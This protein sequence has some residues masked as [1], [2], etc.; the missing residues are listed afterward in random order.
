MKDRRESFPAWKLLLVGMSVLLLLGCAGLVLLWVQH[1]E[2]AEKLVRL[3]SQMQE[4]AQ[5][6]RRQAELLPDELGET[7][8]LRKLRRSRRN[9]EGEQDKMMLVTYSVVPIKAYLDLCNSSRGFCLMGPP[10]PPGVPGPPGPTGAPGP[11]GRRGRPGPPG[12]ACPACCPTEAKSRSHRNKSKDRVTSHLGDETRD[13]LN[14]TGPV[15][16]QDTK[17]ESVSFQKEVI[18]SLNDTRTEN[19][20]Q[21]P[22][23]PVFLAVDSGGNI[24]PSTGGSDV[25]D[26]TATSELVSPRPDYLPAHRMNTSS[27]IRRETLKHL[28]TVSPTPNVDHD[29]KEALNTTDFEKLHHRNF[30]PEI[31]KPHPAENILNGSKFKEQLGTK[32]EPESELISKNDWDSTNVTEDVKFIS[33]EVGEDQNKN[34]FNASRVQTSS[35]SGPPGPPCP[36]CYPTEAKSRNYRNKAKDRV[37]SHLGDETRDVLNVTGPVKLQDTKHESVSFQKEVIVSLNDTRTENVTQT[38]IT[39]VFLA[40]DSG[41]NID[42][43]TGG[44]DVTD[45]TAT[46]ELVSPRPDYL[47]AHRMNTSSEIRRETLKHLTTVSPTPNVDHD[48]KEALN[49]TDFE[50]LHHRNFKP[51][52]PKPH[53]AENILNGSKFKEQ[54]GTKR[55][56][57]SELISKNDWDSKNVTEDVKFISDEVG[58]DQNKNTFN[59][60]R[61]QTSS[62]SDRVTSHLGDET[63]D[64]LN[65]TGPVKLQNTKHESVSFQKEVIVSLNDTRTENVT[66]TPITSVQPTRDSANVTTDAFIVSGSYERPDEKIQPEPEPSDEGEMVTVENS[67][68]PIK[69]LHGPVDTFN[70]SR[71]QVI[72]DTSFKS[73]SSET[74]RSSKTFTSDPVTNETRVKNA[75]PSADDSQRRNSLNGSRNIVDKPMKS[76][77]SQRVPTYKKSNGTDNEKM[78]KKGCNINAIKCSD[79]SINMQL[80]FGAWMS[81][82]SRPDDR[83]WVAEHF[84][85]RE[86]KQ[87]KNISDTKQKFIDI[88]KYYQGCGHVVYKNS[89]YFHNG[90]TN[91]LLKFTLNTKNT[92]SLEMPNSKYKGLRYLFHNSKTYFKFAVDENGLW[93][94]FASYTDSNTMVAK[95]DP[96]AFSVLSIIN[97]GYPSAKAGN[98]FIVCGVVYFTDN[99]DKRVTY[100][101][102]LMTQSYLDASFDLRA[103]DGT[104]AMLSYYPNK[105][106]LYMWDNKSTRT[107]KIKFKNT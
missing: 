104:L 58:E 9:Q 2:L 107:C 5:C 1:K 12:P 52:I 49:T 55:E 19:V 33:D 82:A 16:L 7:G 41:G 30:K 69:L 88:E 26:S 34:T 65:V 35:E 93:V 4:L 72:T 63:R 56:P 42:P 81:D 78:T 96:D 15:K 8:E 97:T 61:V 73:G 40:V 106:L 66:Q 14:V 13:V 50:K 20:T 70:D 36:A 11:H 102:D 100:A 32:R 77:S 95:L 74:N 98:A 54:L 39:P 68:R 51:E 60:S 67:E 29:D 46:S 59:A 43:S 17:H 84:S 57:E 62:E 25:T 94:I 31:P 23:T 3:E 24:D 22:I 45:S 87:L 79:K 38:P 21:T 48:D 6:C 53:P 92:S 89:F 44:S 18:V 101:F 86:L 83:I 28:T 71:G 103:G 99:S 10:G 85:G 27:E 105:R 90:G 37:T 76:E 75:S 64:V 47:P 91:N 80:T